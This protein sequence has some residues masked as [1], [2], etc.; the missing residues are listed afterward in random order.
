MPRASKTDP[1]GIKRDKL[2]IIVAEHKDPVCCPVKAYE[3]IQTKMNMS[4]A[5]PFYGAGDIHG[6][7]TK[8][9]FR[10]YVLKYKSISKMLG[11]E[12]NPTGHSWRA[13]TLTELKTLGYD[14]EFITNLFRW[15]DRSPM[16]EHYDRAKYHIETLRNS[17]L[18][19]N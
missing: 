6:K 18:N 3:F 5:G 14:E 1:W 16:T 9:N 10:R 11:Y 2:A 12:N 7:D 13:S 4:T 19:L 15:A 8:R 17:L